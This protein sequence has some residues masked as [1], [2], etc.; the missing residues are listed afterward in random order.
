M[1]VQNVFIEKQIEFS[2][3]ECRVN[4]KHAQVFVINMQK[5]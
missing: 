1:E 3:M 5:M 4:S 2:T